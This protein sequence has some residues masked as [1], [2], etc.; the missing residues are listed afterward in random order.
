ML[1]TKCSFWTLYGNR[2]QLFSVGNVKSISICFLEFYL[3]SVFIP[4]FFP[5][6]CLCYS[7]CHT[8]VILSPPL[9]HCFTICRYLKIVPGKKASSFVLFQQ[10]PSCYCCLLSAV[11]EM[12]WWWYT[13]SLSSVIFFLIFF[14][15]GGGAMS[16]LCDLLNYAEEVTSLSVVRF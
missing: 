7:W 1:V 6:S 3:H 11:H 10:F 2:C 8:S 13:L 15:F 16:Q 14:F 5:L 12:K 4:F 9:L